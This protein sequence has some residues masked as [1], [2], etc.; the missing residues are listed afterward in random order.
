MVDKVFQVSMFYGD[1]GS[2][3]LELFLFRENRKYEV[4]ND[5]KSLTCPAPGQ[6]CA[7]QLFLSEASGPQWGP[8]SSM[9]CRLKD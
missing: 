1:Y 7:C 9:N 3:G 4:A 5:L 2:V 6:I 8:A